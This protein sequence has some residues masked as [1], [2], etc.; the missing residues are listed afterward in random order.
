VA[1]ICIC[2]TAALRFDES[3]FENIVGAT[4]EANNPSM[5]ITINNSIRVK[6]LLRNAMIT[7]V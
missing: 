3:T 7:P 4:S 5:I 2:V 1:S 6:P